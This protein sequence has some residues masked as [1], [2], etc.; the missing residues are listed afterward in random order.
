[1]TYLIK[2]RINTTWYDV[3]VEEIENEPFKVTVEGEVFEVSLRQNESE[4]GHEELAPSSVIVSNEPDGLEGNVQLSP[5]EIKFFTSPMPGTVLSILVSVG[6]YLMIGDD[7]CLLESMKMQQVLRSDLEGPV[8][9][10]VV[11]VG[12]TILHGDTIL[13]IEQSQD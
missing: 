7:V 1:M 3:E 9:S 8:K 6:D 12:E 10:I 4:I 2:V 5:G 11:S 13:G